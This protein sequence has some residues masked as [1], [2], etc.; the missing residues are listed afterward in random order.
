MALDVP[1]KRPARFVHDSRT[2][3]VT[4]CSVY[5][6][7]ILRCR[8]RKL[9]RALFTGFYP[10]HGDCS[11]VAIPFAIIADETLEYAHNLQRMGTDYLTRRKGF[12]RKEQQHFTKTKKEELPFEC[13]E[14]ELD[15]TEK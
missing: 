2:G 6:L 3:E 11:H 14:M 12:D 13:I 8:F 9:R 15:P 4:L 1:P 5:G 10:Q 7:E